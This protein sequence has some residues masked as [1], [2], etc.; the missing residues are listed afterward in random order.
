MKK[1]ICIVALSILMGALGVFWGQKAW[2]G[3]TLLV[4]ALL[5]LGSV[6]V[7]TILNYFPRPFYTKDDVQAAAR[8]IY[9]DAA[10]HG[11]SIACTHIFPKDNDPDMAL[12][13]LSNVAQGTHVHF[14]RI[15]IMGNQYSDLNRIVSLFERLSENVSITL[16]VLSHCP[17]QFPRLIRVMIPR[18]N[19]LLYRKGNSCTSLVGLDSLAILGAKGEK[20]NFGLLFKSKRVYNLLQEYYDLLLSYGH[21][22]PIKAI[23][24]Y[25][26]ISRNYSLDPCTKFVLAEM[27]NFGEVNPSILQVGIFGSVARRLLG[28]TRR[29]FPREH[30]ADIDLLIV[31]SDAKEDTK[32]NIMEQVSKY[33][34]RN[35]VALTWGP[36]ERYF[37][38]W[39]VPERTNIDIEIIEKGSQ[40]Y[41]QNQLLGRSIFAHYCTLYSFSEEPLCEYLQIPLDVVPKKERRGIL[42]DDRKGLREFADRLANGADDVDPRRIVSLAL[43]NITWAESGQYPCN[44]QFALAFLSDFWAEIFPDLD[45]PQVRAILSCD[46]NVARTR[47]SKFLSVA[48]RIVES[49][50]IY[51]SREP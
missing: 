25:S 38:E 2:F 28:F 9:E 44:S 18:I 49:A 13:K 36:D 50:I 42:L 14:S 11:G 7:R 26:S 32:R 43:R 3:F 6:V 41:Q 29:A 21:V 5:L 46:D 17:L 27:A 51:L 30:E 10:K 31:L 4:I 47:Q 12:D 23:D 16:N 37:Y 33:F 35:E 40:F 20:H 19:L 48:R 8:H 15:M 1:D 22:V 24:E 39:R 34:P 45:L